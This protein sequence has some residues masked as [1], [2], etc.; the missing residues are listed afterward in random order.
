MGIDVA[1]LEICDGEAPG[2][3]IL[4]GGCDVEGEG[5]AAWPE[6]GFYGGA[7]PECCI[8]AAVVLVEWI[9]V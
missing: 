4:G 8:G 9:T 5:G 6:P 7:V 1:A 2:A 3:G